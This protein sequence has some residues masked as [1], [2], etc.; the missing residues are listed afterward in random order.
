MRTAFAQHE[1]RGPPDIKAGPNPSP[2]PNPKPNPTPDPTPN[3]DPNSNPNPNPNPN[4]TL[5]LTLT[6]ADKDA[7]Y[8][9]WDEDNSG[10]LDKEE[11]VRALLK[12]LHMT[13]D[14]LQARSESVSW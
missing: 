6:K 2:N 5:T 10:S 14:P 7:W 11:V 13:H 1:Q 3:P 8:E 4:L 12:T 9:F